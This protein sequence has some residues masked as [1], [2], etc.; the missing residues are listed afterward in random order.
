MMN[1]VTQKGTRSC[2][3][4]LTR[5]ILCNSLHEF[6]HSPGRGVDSGSEDVYHWCQS[7]GYWS[8][9]LAMPMKLASLCRDVEY[10]QKCKVV[11][12]SH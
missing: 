12:L 4:D 3:R 6:S 5:S 2:L 7:R 8:N 9:E 10:E 1:V 11:C